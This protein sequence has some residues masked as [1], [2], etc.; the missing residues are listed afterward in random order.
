MIKHNPKIDVNIS[1][2]QKLK[3]GHLQETRIIMAKIY[4][5]LPDDLK[6]YADMKTLQLAG[7]LHDYGKVL[8]PDKILNKAEQLTENEKKIIEMHSELGY[9]LLKMQGVKEDV[10]KLI[11]YHHQ[12]P[13]KN[14]YPEIDEDF[15]FGIE[16]QILSIS[17]KYSALTEE[18]PY[19]PPYTKKEALEIIHKDVENGVF[20]QEIFD[21]L[22][23]SV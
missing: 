20:I 12:T 15:E 23:K 7:Y 1:E 13:D 6:A 9:E 16:S 17:D 3:H 5:N 11:K 22:A 18:R 21:A 4:S 2:L 8:I 10:L 14:G 19:K